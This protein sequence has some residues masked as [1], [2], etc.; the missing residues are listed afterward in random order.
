MEVF[1]DQPH[2]PGVVGGFEVL[3]VVAT[4]DVDQVELAVLAAVALLREPFV[5][6]QVVLLDTIRR[7]ATGTLA[8]DDQRLAAIGRG[9]R[10]RAEPIRASVILLD[11]AFEPK[12]LFTVPLESGAESLW[13]GDVPNSQTD[14]PVERLQEVDVDL[15]TLIRAR[16]LD[17]QLVGRGVRERPDIQQ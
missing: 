17:L 16:T 7:L 8:P 10:H 13:R 12:S 6:H 5:E 9:A 11:P 14:Q 2:L 3:Q 15:A 4:V 1:L